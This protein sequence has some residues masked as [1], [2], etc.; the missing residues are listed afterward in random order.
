MGAI[1]DN[2]YTTEELLFANLGRAFSHPARK[3]IL[4]IL[5]KDEMKRNIDLSELLNLSQPSVKRHVGIL[6]LADLVQIEYYPHCYMISLNE[7][8]LK[9]M[10]SFIESV[11]N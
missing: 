9:P 1:K 3:R 4:E 5:M 7:K 2:N 11:F 10:K 8:G 6:A